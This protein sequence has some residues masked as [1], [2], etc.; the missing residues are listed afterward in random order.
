MS[1]NGT[2]GKTEKTWPILCLL[3]LPPVYARIVS[4]SQT[5]R[6]ISST[7]SYWLRLYL[8]D[9]RKIENGSS[10]CTIYEITQNKIHWLPLRFPIEILMGLFCRFCCCCCFILSLLVGGCCFTHFRDIPKWVSLASIAFTWHGSLKLNTRV[11]NHFLM[12]Q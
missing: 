8:W 9:L 10:F 3:I 12:K 1:S 4:V 2:F 11:W 5:R 7:L 6:C